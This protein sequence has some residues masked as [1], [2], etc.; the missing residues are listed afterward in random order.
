M[1]ICSP[2]PP[3]HRIFTPN[4]LL[5]NPQDP[6]MTMTV[7]L[8]KDVFEHYP[9]WL[10]VRGDVLFQ[11]RVHWSFFNKVTIYED[12]TS[13]CVYTRD[14][15]DQIMHSVT[16]DDGNVAEFDMST[17]FAL[18]TET[19]WRHPIQRCPNVLSASRTCGLPLIPGMIVCPECF[20]YITIRSRG[21]ASEMMAMSHA[22]G[23][24]PRNL[25][26]I[27]SRM[28]A[29]AH[30]GRPV[31]RGPA[32]EDHS[33]DPPGRGRPGARTRRESRP[34]S[35]RPPT[36]A[37]RAMGGGGVPPGSK[38]YVHWHSIGNCSN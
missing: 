36:S 11:D 20:S 14:S 8:S 35:I 15:R 2:W 27:T 38:R 21:P 33:E 6:K 18:M 28:N 29:P 22:P 4:Y 3:G 19:N 37:V 17:T 31:L 13:F 12:T 32:R 34:P 1:V 24:Y 30:P 5:R 7:E 26:A 10:S 16:S 25:Q 9:A 23:S